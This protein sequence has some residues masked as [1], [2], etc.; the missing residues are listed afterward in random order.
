[1]SDQLTKWDLG[2]ARNFVHHGHR[3]F[4]KAL[5]GDVLL[6]NKETGELVGKVAT[7][8]APGALRC[9]GDDLED[10]YTNRCD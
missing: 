7:E 2:R 8:L 4:G 1:M 5:G 9:D 3:S 10:T 6:V